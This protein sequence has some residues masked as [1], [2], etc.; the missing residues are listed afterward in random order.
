MNIEGTRAYKFL[1]AEFALQDLTKRQIK[2][3]TFPDMNDPFE[4]LGGL[5]S[6]P[7]LSP[8]LAARVSHIND[9]CGVLCFSRD[10]HNA[11]LW[12]HYGDKHRGICLGLDISAEVH[13]PFYVANRQEF[14]TDLRVLLAAAPRR[15]GLTP[16]DPEFQACE[17]AVAR[18]LLTKYDAWRYEN[19]VRT[20]IA[21]KAE[22][23]QGPFYFAE[24]DKHFQPRTIIL[25][26][27]CAT[28]AEDI[29]AAVVGYSPPITVVRTVLSG[30][31]FEVIDQATAPKAP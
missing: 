11:M 1:P 10:W 31:A 16:S 28:P 19:E 9:W 5:R 8:H 14:D 24:I 4:L 7:Q 13:E 12:S 23:R 26:A 29:E 25:G 22:Q 3:S 20:F 30:S 17:Q 21:L 27:R 6:D 2:I 18:I 15:K